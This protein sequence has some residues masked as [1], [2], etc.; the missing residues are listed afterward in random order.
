MSLDLWLFFLKMLIYMVTMENLVYTHRFTTLQRGLNSL[1]LSNIILVCMNNWAIA[2]KKITSLELSVLYSTPNSGNR[3][4]PV[5][6]LL[7]WIAIT[8]G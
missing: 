8:L 2:L 4:N 1:Q 6:N 7:L 3:F 5:L